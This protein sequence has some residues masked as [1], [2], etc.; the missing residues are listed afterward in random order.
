MLLTKNQ[1]K[2]IFYTYYFHGFLL[3]VENYNIIKI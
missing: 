3:Q 1:F 2:N